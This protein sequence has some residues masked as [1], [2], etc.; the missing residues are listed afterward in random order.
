M[1]F[2]Q[3]TARA[4]EETITTLD[5]IV[6]LICTGVVVHFPEPEANKRHGMATI[7]FDRWR[8]HVGV[9]PDEWLLEFEIE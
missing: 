8:S 9:G 6:D 1:E 3:Y 5:G 2:N 7:E 4:I